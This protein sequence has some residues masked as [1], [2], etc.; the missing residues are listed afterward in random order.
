MAFCFYE[1]LWDF[2]YTC[3]LANVTQAYFDI[4]TDNYF[5]HGAQ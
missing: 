2:S 3:N 1:A 5:T 4:L